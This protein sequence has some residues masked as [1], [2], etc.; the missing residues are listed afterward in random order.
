MCT[1][2]TH[3]CTHTVWL[4]LY[5]SNPG[6]VRIT[7][8]VMDWFSSV[9]H[10]R[11]YTHALFLFFS[12][13]NTG[14]EQ[15]SSVQ[16]MGRLCWAGLAVRL[17]KRADSWFAIAIH[18]PEKREEGKNGALAQGCVSQIRAYICAA[19]SFHWKLAFFVRV[20][21]PKHVFTGTCV[22]AYV[23]VACKHVSQRCDIISV[24]TFLKH[25]AGN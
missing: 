24:K 16:S 22:V 21:M 11:I 7:I 3:T 14:L 4:T 10:I 8:C 20:F 25:M 15:R 23:S 18:Q 19:V 17:N 6:C 5:G 12:S 2:H 1:G 13:T 9:F